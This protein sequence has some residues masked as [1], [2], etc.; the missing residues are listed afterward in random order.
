MATLQSGSRLAS[1]EILALIGSGG[2]GEVYRARDS[3]LKRD[4]AIKVLP[5]EFSRD[6]ERL[7]RAQREAEVLASLNHPHIAQIYGQEESGEAHCLVL[8]F[9]DGETL[10][11]RLARGPIPMEETLEFA[12]QIADAL[13]AAHERGIVHR[14]L[15]PANIKIT[16]SG[17]IKVLDFGLAKAA[18]ADG[19]NVAASNS[20][21]MV[22]GTL[23]GA[24][25]G[26]AAYM[27][28]E[29]AKGRAADARSDIWAF[30]V[31]LYE[32]LTGKQAFEGETIVEILGSVMK[33]E[34]NWTALPE[35]TL[36]LIRSLLR[37][38][39]Q[40]DRK[41]RLRDIADARFQ[42]E[43]A[44]NEPLSPAIVLPTA[45]K[46]KERIAWIAAGLF[47]LISLIAAGTLYFRA[48]PAELHE[49]RLD[50]ATPPTSQP[51]IF[52]I[53]PDGR[54]VIFQATT[55]GKTQLW[56]RRFESETAQPLQGTDNAQAPFWSP[57]SQSIAFTADGK[58]KRIDVA[59]GPVRSLADSLMN[60]GT[61]NSDG[62]ILFKK[63]NGTGLA[64]ISTSGAEIVEAT[65]IAPPQQAD[66]RLPYFLPDGRHFLYFVIG[67]PEGR[68]IYIGSLDSNE[69]KRVL[70][71]ELA[72]T[73]APPD[74]LLFVREDTLW[75]QHLN[76]KTFELTGDP[77]SVAEHVE[78]RSSTNGRVAVSASATGAIA[79][80]GTV[81]QAQQMVWIDRSGKQIGVVGAPDADA[82][83]MNRISPDGRTAVLVRTINGN[84]DVWL[85]NLSRALLR[86]FTSDAGTD[87]AGVWSPDGSR[88]AYN[89]WRKGLGDI[90]VK[91]TAGGNAAPILETSENKN[92]SDWSPDGRFILYSNQSRTTDRDLWALPLDGDRKPFVLAQTPAAEGNG[93]FS[94]DGR[95][96]AYQSNE[97]GR[98]EIYVQP[99]PG[100]GAK[101][102]ISTGGGEVP[103]WRGDGRELFYR[104][105]DNRLMAV[106]VTLNPDRKTVE[107]GTPVA[108]FPTRVGSTYEAAPDGQRFLLLT[109]TEE[110]S[111]APITVILNWRK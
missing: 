108:L 80:R 8:E 12:R 65:R 13:E 64:R 5:P 48:A 104:A 60:S 19:A 100:S 34:P 109:P 82:V 55:E 37:R 110:A 72:G 95:W 69:T 94:P 1:Y 86:R 7:A 105:P 50:I 73:F 77:F 85:M 56:L 14:D 98:N 38:C 54:K 89:G 28:P 106:S 4:V 66:H 97:S 51:T 75:A 39:L 87:G 52:A 24:I 81:T 31:V 58:L 32:M 41:K 93:R 71:S 21:T 79:Y 70:D 92:L 62:V 15:K 83:G 99:F 43:E 78:Q 107:T 102:Q 42:I 3:K 67:T 10:Q 76:L 103:N 49:T 22:S 84:Q 36:P 16:P 27:S 46:S 91:P 33:V 2:M 74:F 90:Y 47:G 44:L 45:R 35:T 30:G 88:I 59:G 68:G 40:K 63:A 9:V 11:E 25:L 20:P 53:S 96:V 29:Q 18:D 26:T 101:T 61:W 6:T 57:D 111:T 23:S 17:Q